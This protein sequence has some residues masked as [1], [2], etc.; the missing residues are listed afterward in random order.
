MS[1][2]LATNRD[3]VLSLP[4]TA[5]H[6]DCERCAEAR[7]RVASLYLPFSPTL[8]FSEAADR[9][10]Q[11]RQFG[12]IHSKVRY[13]APN[14]LKSYRT[15]LNALV[16]FFGSMTLGSI[17]LGNVEAYRLERCEKAGPNKIIQEENVL[18][19]IL[20]RAGC[21]TS[22]MDEAY[23][24]IQRVEND[25]PRALSPEEQK[26]WLEVANS[27]PRWQIVYLYSVVAMRCAMSNCEMRGLKLQDVNLYQQIVTVQTRHAKNKFRIRSIPLP[28][29][30]L[31]CVERLMERAKSIGSNLPDHYLFPF[32]LSHGGKLGDVYKPD[33]P[34]SE[35]GIDTYWDEVRAVSGLTRFRK[36][37]CRHTGITR[38][39]EAGVPMPVILS[40]AGH[41][42][43]R[44]QAHYT[45]IS[46]QAKRK[47]VMAAYEGTMYDDMKRPVQNSGHPRNPMKTA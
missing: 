33:R 19:S 42:S 32:Q 41:I 46:E 3:N 43:L 44:M 28:P 45:H 26:H 2:Q 15:Y 6:V 30:A 20:K 39:A 38:W 25:I 27:D 36:H 21:W 10:L 29:D 12:K 34:M 11:A 13:C 16:L 22:E 40:M 37:D 8:L 9:W 1:R 23:V 47:A 35:W 4:H 24:P 31:W 17:D 7:Q 14:T 5:G 18:I